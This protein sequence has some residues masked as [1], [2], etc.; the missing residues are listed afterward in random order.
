M[1][2]LVTYPHEN[3]AIKNIFNSLF[4]ILAVQEKIPREQVPGQTNDIRQLR[5]LC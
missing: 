3:W 4:S 1:L 5:V 2:S